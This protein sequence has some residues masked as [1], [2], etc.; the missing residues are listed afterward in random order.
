MAFKVEEVGSL[1]GRAPLGRLLKPVLET[2]LCS[3]TG[4]A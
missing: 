2:K 4:N 1:F 3:G